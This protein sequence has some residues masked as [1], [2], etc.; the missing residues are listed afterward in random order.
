MN[1]LGVAPK[2]QAAVSVGEEQDDFR[3]LECGPRNSPVDVR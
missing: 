2:C 3:S 1:T